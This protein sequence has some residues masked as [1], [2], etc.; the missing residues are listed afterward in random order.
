LKARQVSVSLYG[1]QSPSDAL[2]LP[3]NRTDAV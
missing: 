1:A 3:P 2:R